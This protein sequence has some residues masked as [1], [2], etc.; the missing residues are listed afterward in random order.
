MNKKRW[1]EIINLLLDGETISSEMLAKKLKLSSRTVRNELKMLKS[2][3]D[4]GGAQL[5]SKTKV[6]YYLIIN[7]QTVFKRFLSYLNDSKI[8]PDTAQER[9]QFLLETL[10]ANNERYIKLEDLCDQ[11][12]ISRSSLSADLKNVREML[13]DYNL[14]LL[15]RPGYGIKVEGNEFDLRLCI[16]SHTIRRIEQDDTHD[17]SSL[18]LI[19]DCIQNGLKDT[20]LKL[21]EMSYQNLI[22][23]IFIAL[24]RIEEG[25]YVPLS[26]EQMKTIKHDL[27][28]PYAAMIVKQ[29]TACFA[30]AIPEPEIGY[31]AIHLASKRI[32][33]EPINN[34]NFVINSEVVDIVDQMLDE[35]KRSYD[36]D[37]HN[38]LE[39][40]MI[41]AMHLIPLKVRLRYDMNL[42]NPLLKDIKTLYTFSYMLAVSACSVLEKEYHKHIQEDEI[43][44]IAL[45]ISLA[46]ERRKNHRLKKNIVIVCS[47]GRGSAQLLEWK[48]R[49]K[50]GQYLNRIETCDVLQMEKFDLND[51]DYVV[52][53]VPIPFPIIRPIFH[54]PLFIE[55]KDVQAISNILSRNT[56]SSWKNIFDEK[57]F[58]SGLNAE[59]KESVIAQMVDRI[60]EV[61]KIPDNFYELV[62]E[63]ERLAVTEFGN[64]VAIPHPN[65][66]VSD[67]T[68]VCI[69]ILNKPIRWDK[70]KVQ[71]V[72]MLSLKT[73]VDDDIRYFTRISSKLLFDN[74]YINEMIR[75]PKYSTLML[76]LSSIENEI[77]EQ[78]G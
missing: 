78:N 69:A 50:F 63:R 60:K 39:L 36:I 66:A 23:H 34:G 3:L 9:I 62:L 5:Y 16:A 27:E 76:L 15:T 14:Q 70:Q 35:V 54:I 46:L 24:K 68:F 41:M 53:T 61:R 29:L 33:E 51:F 25:C 56:D 58:L 22:V 73:P 20:E 31:I 13:E 44:Y 28:Y 75:S 57:L 19:A 74:K 10:L 4:K 8:I 48:F 64:L 26:N 42:K 65:A 12:Y 7:D 21:S 30:I 55:E 72:Y 18:R 2:I 49:E 67:Q 32:I 47:T 59:T 1:S 71:F 11:L 43:G 37:L 17:Q 38:D 40:R 45:H 6:G 77:E 52:S